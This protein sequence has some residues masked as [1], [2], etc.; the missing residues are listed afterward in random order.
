[1]HIIIIVTDSNNKDIYDTI[2]MLTIKNGLIKWLIIHNYLI[3][4]AD[5]GVSTHLHHG[6]HVLHDLLH[7]HVP[8]GTSHLQVRHSHCLSNG[9]ALEALDRWDILTTFFMMSMS[10]QIY[11]W[12]IF[13]C[14]L[15][16]LLLSSASNCSSDIQ[17]RHTND[18][19]LMFPMR[20][21]T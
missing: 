21:Y 5:W 14:Y 11:W 3:N 10:L 17:V 4:F 12:G 8:W 6:S 16:G 18:L 13:S 1:M 19:R 20:L 9:Y 15:D 7:V 2:K